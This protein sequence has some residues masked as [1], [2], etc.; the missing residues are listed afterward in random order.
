MHIKITAPDARYGK[1]TYEPGKTYEVADDAGNAL[2]CAGQ[3]QRVG[4]KADGMK[5][6]LPPADAPRCESPKNPEEWMDDDGQLD[7]GRDPLSL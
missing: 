1:V 7:Q 2:V 6:E 5:H 3:A 4:G